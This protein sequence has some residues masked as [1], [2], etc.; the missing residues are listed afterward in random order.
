MPPIGSG[1]RV[2]DSRQRALGIGRGGILLCLCSLFRLVSRDQQ[3][4]LP[5]LQ[6]RMC[7]LPARLD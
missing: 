2:G 7:R 4:R 6:F 5:S 3:G 1:V